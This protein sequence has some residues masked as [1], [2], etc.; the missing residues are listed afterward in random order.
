[1]FSDR[2]LVRTITLLSDAMAVRAFHELLPRIRSLQ[3]TVIYSKRPP[4]L[5]CS[6]EP[7]PPVATRQS[8][9]FYFY[10]LWASKA[11]SASSGLGSVGHKSEETSGQ[12]HGMPRADIDRGFRGW[13]GRPHVDY[14]TN[15][16]PVRQ[17]S[18]KA[19]SSG[20]REST[21][22]KGTKNMPLTPKKWKRALPSKEVLNAVYSLRRVKRNPDGIKEVM[23]K[24]VSRLLK[25]EMLLVLSEL[26]R[27]DEWHLAHQV[28]TM[29]RKESWYKPDVYLFQTMVQVFGRNKRIKE[30]EK[31][32]EDL[33]DEG[34][35][36][37]ESIT[38]ELLRA[39]VTSGMMPEAI[40]LYKEILEL[41]KDQAARSILFHGLSA[42]DKEELSQ[43]E[44]QKGIDWSFV[45]KR[46]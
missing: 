12:V 32:F 5:V 33:E 37:N 2:Y 7:G 29:I 40:K 3:Y 10:R 39:Y 35:H 31:I 21:V 16:W 20:Y 44:R 41:G 8:V 24:Y 26:Q 30:A 34:L 36:P 42:E 43:Y 38:R 46:D 1:M 14:A 18:T 28:F 17:C 15:R 4:E 45:E 19:S 11:P 6:S 22:A 13:D 23:R 9:N 27:L 25:L